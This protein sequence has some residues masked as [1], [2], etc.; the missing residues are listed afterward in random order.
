MSFNS[1]ISVMCAVPLALSAGAGFAKG[2]MAGHGMSIENN[3][4]DAALTYSPAAG[5]GAVGAYYGLMLNVVNHGDGPGYV[6]KG[7]AAGIVAGCV[8][9][10][11]GFGLGYMLSKM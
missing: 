6:L 1:D 7:T 8:A 11:A 3:L 9:Q 5:T 10:A 2:Y 4:L